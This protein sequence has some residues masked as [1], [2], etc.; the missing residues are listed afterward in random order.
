[1]LVVDDDPDI[2]SVLA[3][4]LRLKGF[5][6]TTEAR[7]DAAA[8]RLRE[9]AFDAAVI[10]V[11]IGAESGLDLVVGLRAA[12]V[13]LPV[14]M[15]SALAEIADRAAGLRAGADDY[16]VKPLDLDELA[17]RL[18]VQISR[19][20]ETRPG[21]PELDPGRRRLCCGTSELD[22]T[23]REFAVLRLLW[24]HRGGP[25]ARGEI[26]DRLWT[27]DTPGAENVV[28]VYIGYLR[29]KLAQRPEFGLQ[30]VTIRSRGFEL[31]GVS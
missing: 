4:G 24:E 1:M 8:A 21:G 11:M 12:G 30:I 31:R 25:L 2:A 6:V 20:A 15:L 17:A 22:L 7:A 5:E 27:G 13:D 28:D 23:E 9:D 16:V 26:F 3:R 18:H 29:K 19:A 14:L 10:D